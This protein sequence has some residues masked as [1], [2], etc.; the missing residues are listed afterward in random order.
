MR[1]AWLLAALAL[2]LLAQPSTA[3]PHETPSA[4]GARIAAQAYV[5][6]LA[7]LE[8]QRVIDNFPP[9]VLL[10]VTQLSTPAQRLVVAPNVDTLYT[11]ARLDLAAG[12]LV[13]HVPA[14]RGRYYTMQLLDAY[15]NSFAYVGR[16]ATGT[17]AG[18][19][20]IAGPGWH[21]PLPRGVHRIDAPTR[22]VWLL[23]RTLVGGPGDLA[24]AKAVQRGY[25]LSR[26]GGDAPIPP[27]FLAR[28]TLM[29]LPLPQGLSLFDALGATLASNPPAA[30]AQ[31]GLLAGF[32][33][34]GIGPGS[35]PSTDAAAA[36]R[37]PFLLAGIQSAQ[38]SLARY[39]A[40]IANA[41]E[42]AHNGW[43]LP[44][45][46]VGNFGR[47]YLLRAYVANHALAANVPAE[48]IYP[49][50]FVDHVGRKLTGARRYQ[51]HFAP[52][53]LPPVR[54]FWSLT[55]Y[56][57]SIFLVP[58]AID[59]YAVSD[60]TAGLR[61]NRD[62]SLDVYLQRTAPR[63]AARRAN[64]LPSPAGTFELALR[65]YQPKPVVLRGRWPLPTVFRLG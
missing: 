1:H 9:N 50:A 52:G 29:P 53:E 43:L 20:A 6:A 51:V 19:W 41:S 24:A 13:L 44:P 40:R 26:P 25:A 47:N 10:N 38:R 21:G 63:L 30:A 35:S 34:V 45:C 54:A 57:A 5:Y 37:R 46:G 65:L 28:S 32:A 7:P 59:R 16:R 60:R 3:R 12:P 33:S 49:F 64:W 23:G 11:T 36:P 58:N 8:E 55:M 15:T 56:D 48:A 22:T 17:G 39:A 27:V 4:R 18:D 62:G 2:L 42:R 31:R 14:E 61:R